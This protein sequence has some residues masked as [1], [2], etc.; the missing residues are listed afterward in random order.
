VFNV[1]QCEGIPESLI[2]DVRQHVQP[3]A[4]CERVISE[5]PCKPIIEHKEPRAYYS[6]LRDLVN[7]PEP[8]LFESDE[9]YYATLF[10]ELVHST[11]HHSRCNRKG[12]ERTQEFGSEAY[13]FE[14]LVA[15]IGACYLQSHTGIASK[16]F[17]CSIGYLKGWLNR[18]KD[19][20]RFIIRASGLAQKATDFILNIQ[21]EGV[22]DNDSSHDQ[23]AAL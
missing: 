6:P 22:E 7:M 2:P 23:T 15:E 5:M 18:L 8:A 21:S 10:H 12:F 17:D 4:E 16:Q 20:K 3:I 1:A 19:D 13:S 14:E 9:S 11:G